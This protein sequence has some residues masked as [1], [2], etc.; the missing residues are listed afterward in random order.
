MMCPHI[1]CAMQYLKHMDMLSAETYVTLMDKIMH[2]FLCIDKLKNIMDDL[3]YER[4]LNSE[5]YEV[6][7]DYEPEDSLKAPPA[8]KASTLSGQK[9]R[10]Q[11][12]GETRKEKVKKCD[13][14]VKSRRYT[15][16]G[17]NTKV[18]YYSKY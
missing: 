14:K 8:Y 9:R 10:F 12:K 13:K 7:K 15:I 17:L 5:L 3:Q 11:S 2:P 1:L 4:I 18:K 16:L 6:V